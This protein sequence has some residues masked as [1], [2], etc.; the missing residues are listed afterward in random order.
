[1]KELKICFYGISKNESC[2]VPHHL[3]L[4]GNLLYIEEGGPKPEA[5]A[6]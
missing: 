3:R 1:M 2:F 4:R 6:A 5:G